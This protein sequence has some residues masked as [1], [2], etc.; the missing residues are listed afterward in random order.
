MTTDIKRI[1]IFYEKKNKGL[2]EREKKGFCTHK[3]HTWEA[4]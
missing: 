1:E 3:Q 4:F 2:K